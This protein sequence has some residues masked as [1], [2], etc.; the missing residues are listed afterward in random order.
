MSR[1]LGMLGV[2]LAG[3]VM[4]TG[5]SDLG[6]PVRL[7]ARGELSVPLLD[8]GT[9]AVNH[10]VSRTLT[11]RNTGQADLAG[12]ATLPCSAIQ[13]TSGGG[14]FSVPPNG[15]HAIV[16]EY[17][18]SAPETL[19]CILDLGPG[20]PR[21][22]LSAVG[23]LQ[24]P[25]ARC[26]ILPDSLDFGVLGVGQRVSAE[27][28]IFNTGTDPLTVDPVSSC[29]DFEVELGGGAGDIAPGGSRVVR[30]AFVPV[31]GGPVRCGVEVGPGCPLVPV[32][33]SGTTV[34]FATGVRPALNPC[35]GCHDWNDPVFG[36]AE[37]VN[38]PSGYGSFKIVQPFDP[39]NSV[40]Y[41]KITTSGSGRFG[42]QMPPSGARVSAANKAKIR[43]WILEGAHNN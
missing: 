23:A 17:Q 34:S 13:I 10:S 43:T 12:N 22:P 4:L 26:S 27:F 25:G 18:P 29:A 40:L 24:A 8:F 11:V 21:V 42:G 20:L 3:L 41:V 15:S 16:F 1:R 2:V 5:C 38:A 33:G 19:T 39:D 30:V 6:R 32:K 28:Q 9:V 35:A 36:Y 7:E 31:E 37:M 14:P